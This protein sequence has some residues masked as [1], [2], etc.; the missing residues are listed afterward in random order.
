VSSPFWWEV[1]CADV[2]DGLREIPDRSV[3]CVVTSPPYFGLRDYGTAEWEGG[4]DP[5]CD[6]VTSRGGN[7]PQTLKPDV[8]YPVSAHRGGDPSSC[9]KCGATRI[10]AQI[11]LEPSPQAYVDRV[12]G[13]F[14]E[15]RR[16]LRDDGTVWL[17]LGDSF[18]AAGRDSHGSRERVKQGT[19]R[20]SA[21]G[22]DSVRP[23]DGALKAKN[24]MMIPARV[25]IALQDDGWYLRKDVIWAKPNPMPESV[26]DRP[27]SSHEHVFLLAKS[28]R[29]FYDL[30]AVR[31]PQKGLPTLWDDGGAVEGESIAEGRQLLDV[32]WIVPQSR[33]E[34]QS[35]FATFPFELARRCISLSTSER[36]AC[37]ECGA[38]WRRIVV[39][40]GETT[41]RHYKQ[42][43]VAE[44]RGI[45]GR[46]GT[47]I[48]GGTVEAA[49]RVTK[50]WE[51]TCKHPQEDTPVGCVVL[52]PFAGSGTAGIIA[53]RMWRSFVGID[54]KPE[55]VALARRLIREDA[56]WNEWVERVPEE[57]GA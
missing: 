52:D 4:N 10:D 27:S 39:L 43:A 14:R 1:K 8:G 23:Q 54:L 56:S 48:L 32:W 38:P 53:T 9:P 30:D 37:P 45:V 51:P 31:Q 57:A 22:V 36:G 20:A 2:I 47:M 17:N 19:N 40:V 42:A 44:A 15:V 49:K 50:G 6:H 46:G 3:Q 26:V 21:T 13:V 28:G 29:Y 24:Q 41:G 33:P 55:Y 11:G 35:H 16:V 12:V 25:A 18:N 7:V 34:V 5:A